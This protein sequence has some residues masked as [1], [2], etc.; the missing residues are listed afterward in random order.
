[1]TR[2]PH[3]QWTL[4][5]SIAL[6]GVGAGTG[7]ADDETAIDFELVSDPNVN[8]TAQVVDAIDSVLVIV[9]SSDGLYTPAEAMRVGNVQIRNADANP[10]DL[11]LVALVP[12]PAGRLPVIRLLQGGLPDVALDVRVIGVRGPEDG[13]A[14]A[15]GHV[16]GTRFEAA[17]VTTSTVP[18]NIRPE[19][20]PPRVVD[21]L[22]RDGDLAP[23][24]EV[25]TLVVMF[26]KPMDAMSLT[27]AGRILTGPGG[28][29]TEVTVD[30]SGL[31][32]VVAPAGLVGA[33]M[34]SVGYR[35]TVSSEA[36]DRDGLAL[37]QL[38]MQDGA[39]G[40]AADFVL[41]CETRTMT[42]DQV[43]CGTMG[44]PGPLPTY[45]PGGGR[46]GCVAGECV[47]ASCE[48][49]ECATGFVCDATTFACTADCRPYGDDVCPTDRPTCDAATGACH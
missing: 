14:V 11:E 6:A 21:V 28:M 12:V 35:L 10:D 19:L 47:L 27:A 30:S 5:W 16:S 20:L 36:L 15:L 42:P 9:D 49:A 3:G 40:F 8:S 29:P 43:A 1:M 48:A 33:D 23:G 18:F 31:V 17:R 22:P 41:R 38:P 24:C 44:V 7:C 25:A 45:C 4:L 39:Q 13:P 32:A 46:L 2:A 26:S 34:M 37:D